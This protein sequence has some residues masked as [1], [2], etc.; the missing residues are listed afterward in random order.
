MPRDI[1]C[2]IVNLYQ[3]LNIMVANHSQHEGN[4]QIRQYIK[5]LDINLI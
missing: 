2:L 1:I 5:V 4:L 3:I